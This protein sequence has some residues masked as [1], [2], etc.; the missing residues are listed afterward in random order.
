MVH[1]PEIVNP[2]ARQKNS[3]TDS[4]GN[5]G[6]TPPPVAD[7][8]NFLLEKAQPVQPF[9]ASYKT[10]ISA[11]PIFDQQ[12]IPDC[13]ENAITYVK[14][15]HE[16]KNGPVV[17][18]SRRFLAALTVAR[19]GFPLDEGTSIENALY[20]AHKRGICE[21]AYFVDDHALSTKPFSDY[22][23]ISQTAYANG[24]KHT[25]QSYAFVS[26]LSDNGL[27]NAIYQNGLVVVGA[28]INQNWWTDKSGNV[29]WDSSD[30]LPIRPPATRDASIDTSLGGHAFVLYGYDEQY[31]YFVNSFGAEWASS[32]CGYFKADEVPYI[33][34]AATMLDLDPTQVALIKQELATVQQDVKTIDPS[35]PQFEQELGMLAQVVHY[36]INQI[37]LV[38][39]S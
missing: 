18:L 29:S 16:S 33:Y 23:L 38:F 1:L 31:F 2:V 26:D 22:A 30:I 10:D 15:Y 36:I 37:K 35:S 28:L 34:E 11:L 27:K 5:T 19:D 25:I 13:V 4:F 8:R 14:K 24:L 39:W 12:K 20:E 32:G 6:Y 9:P 17:D 21:V 7:K 3:M